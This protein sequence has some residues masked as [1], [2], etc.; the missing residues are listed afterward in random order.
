VKEGEEIMAQSV[1]ALPASKHFQLEQVAEGIYAALSIDGTG[2]MCNAGIIDL[3]DATLVFDTFVTLHAAQDLRQA[4]EQLLERPVA[5]V[6]NSHKDS[7]HYW[8]NQIFVP[9]ATI[10]ATEKTRTELFSRV[11]TSNEKTQLA[12][13]Q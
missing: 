9:G 3:G 2:S 8:G 5:Y 4:A 13:H 11:N 6:V 7:D 12:H 1:H 10:I